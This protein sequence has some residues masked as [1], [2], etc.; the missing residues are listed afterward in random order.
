[1]AGILDAL[2]PTTIANYARG[3]W[4][5]ITLNSWL[6]GEFKKKGVFQYDVGGDTL[7]GPVEAGRYQP[8]ISAPGQD[9]SALFVPKVRHQRWNFSWGEIV[10][11]LSIDRGLLRRNSGDQALVR[12]KDT[13]IP[14]LFRDLVIAPGG[15]VYHML[16]TDGAAF[17]GTGLP[18]YGLPSFL[19]PVSDLANLNGFN[20]A[21]K[22]LPASGTWTASAAG[23]TGTTVAVA[24]PEVCAV[25]QT[26]GGLSLAPAGLNASIDAA[27]WDAWAPTMVNGDSSFFN[28]VAGT[29]D[30]TRQNIIELSLQYL[31]TRLTRFSAS[32]QSLIPNIGVLDANY[33][34]LL[35]TRKAGRETVFVTTDQKSPIVPD[36]GF[37]A[38]SGIWHAGIMWRWEENMP[39]STA[40]AGNASRMKCWIQPLYKDQ[41][42]GSPL[43]VSGAEAGIMET[44]INFDPLRRQYLVSATVPGQLTFEPRY[45]GCVRQYKGT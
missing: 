30:A 28:G 27:Q 6:L 35:G 44:A 20:P 16:N 23:S 22:A 3:A 18:F 2:S 10:N 29:T 31:L 21:T 39:G 5:G 42:N 8:T 34:R 13:E 24:D 25:A 15:F 19:R 43:R 11:A 40:Y 36:T 14:A 4:D 17:T 7:S 9:I 38:I 32:D 26:Y 12:L 1:M 41:D 37:P 45:W 33:Y